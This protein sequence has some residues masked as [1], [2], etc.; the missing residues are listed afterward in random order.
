[1]IRAFFT[2]EVPSYFHLLARDDP[3]RLRDVYRESVSS[4]VDERD[5]IGP[6]GFYRERNP[7]NLQ[8]AM[9]MIQPNNT[10]DAAIIL[11][12]QSTIVR[13]GPDGRLTNANDLIRCGVAADADRNSD[14]L[15]VSE[16]NTLARKRAD[17]TLADPV[18]LYLDG[19][20]TA[21]WVAPDGADPQT[22]WTITRGDAD[23]AVRAE[24]AVA[25]GHE[26]T[27][28]DITI[29]GQRITSPSQIAEGIEVKVVGLAHGFGKSTAAPRACARDTARAGVLG[30][31][32]VGGAGLADADDDELPSV[33]SLIAAAR[34]TR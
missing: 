5:L 24:F 15:I 12:A 25:D 11:V 18:G 21:G 14:P 30:G 13:D 28:S 3:K 26:Y 20:Q 29:N 22:F 23:H 9:H 1:L 19:L 8:G 27:V 7:W 6:S 34:A 32:E 33:A 4:E 16:V 31:G 17:I 10:L 2:T